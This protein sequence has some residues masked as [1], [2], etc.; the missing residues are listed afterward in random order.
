MKGPP[1]LP[2]QHEAQLVVHLGVQLHR[3]DESSR[4]CRMANALP[5]KQH[6]HQR[7]WTL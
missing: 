5:P 3:V 7:I 1:S 4:Y 6:G 2:S